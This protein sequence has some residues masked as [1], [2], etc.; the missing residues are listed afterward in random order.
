MSKREKTELTPPAALPNKRGF[1]KWLF[2]HRIYALVFI[3]PFVLMYIVYAVFKVHPWGDNS[4]L[5][6]DLNGQYVYY[7]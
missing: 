7:Y 6:L 4:V 3:I 1:K 2:E 5:V